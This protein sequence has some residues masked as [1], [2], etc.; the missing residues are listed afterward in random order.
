M[1]CCGKGTS[2]SSTSKVRAV[3]WGL[4]YEGT[5]PTHGGGGSTFTDLLASQRPHSIRALGFQLSTL[6]RTHAFRPQTVPLLAK[7]IHRTIDATSA[8]TKSRDKTDEKEAYRE[9]NSHKRAKHPALYPRLAECALSVW[10][11]VKFLFSCFTTRKANTTVLIHLLYLSQSFTP[12][13]IQLGHN[14]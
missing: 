11:I 4:L 7:P 5:N 14:N 8:S 12:R 13:E 6:G 2:V 9:T 10:L 1:W 3:P